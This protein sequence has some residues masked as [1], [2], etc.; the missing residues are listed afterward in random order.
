MKIKGVLFLWVIFLSH[1]IVFSQV[2]R[3]LIGK[4]V[5]REHIILYD[6]FNFTRDWNKIAQFKSGIGETVDLFPII[7]SVPSKKI[8]LT[9][10]QLD[11]EVKPQISGTIV[12]RNSSS[13]IN[14][15]NKDFIKRTVFIDKVDVSRMVSYIERDI[16]PNLKTTFKKK[17]KEYVFKSNELFFSFLINEKTARITM[18]IVDFGPL[19]DGFGGGEQ[20]EFWTESKIDDIPGL[21]ETLKGFYNSMK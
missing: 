18:H 4:S 13:V 11:A 9:G 10:L 3:T 6:E 12:Y 16:I 15:N 5:I 8:E 14:L 20:I 17:S 7:F 21:L 1:N 19:G 2:Q